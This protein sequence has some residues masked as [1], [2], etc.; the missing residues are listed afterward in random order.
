MLDAVLRESKLRSSSIEKTKGTANG[1]SAIR[2]EDDDAY[3]RFMELWSPLAGEIFLDWLGTS[4]GLRWARCL[5]I[6]RKNFPL[7]ER[8]CPQNNVT[9]RF[10]IGTLRRCDRD[11]ADMDA[12]IRNAEG[13]RARVTAMRKY[14]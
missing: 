9:G 11:R 3:G 14:R 4:P 12:E 8:I 6:V 13:A 5:K 10:D 1:R 7:T 2:F